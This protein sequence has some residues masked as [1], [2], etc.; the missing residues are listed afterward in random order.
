MRAARYLPGTMGQRESACRVVAVCLLL[1]LGACADKT[2]APQRRKPPRPLT[3]P[4]PR[5]IPAGPPVELMA[6]T[7]A[8]PFLLG[9]V[10]IS[11]VDRLLSNGTKLVSQAMPLPMDAA[12]LRDMILSQAG[13]AARGLREPGLRQPERGGVR[14]AGRQGQERRRAGGAG[15]RAGRGAEDYR[16]ARQEDHRRAGRRRWSRATRAAAAGCTAP[17]TSSC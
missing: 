13:P 12:G 1:G 11:S 17:A 6:A 5:G 10:A 7:A 3:T 4:V 15:A 8:R 9:T 14:R 2:P 16:R